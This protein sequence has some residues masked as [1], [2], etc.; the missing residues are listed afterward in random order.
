MKSRPFDL[1]PT[2]AKEIEECAT[3]QGMRAR[4]N[5]YSYHDPLT[6][7]IFNSAHYQG[8]SGEDKMTWLAFEALKFR[9]RYM[10][11]AL[12]TAMLSVNPPSIKVITHD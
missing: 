8:L 12:E 2:T 7:A 10:D 11:D 3:I 1:N 5:Q 9:E 6:R 4:L